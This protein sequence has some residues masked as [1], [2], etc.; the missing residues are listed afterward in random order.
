MY[1]ELDALFQARNWL[2]FFDIDYGG[3]AGGV[4]TAAC[5]PEALHSL[6]N[7]L[8][9]H[10][11]KELFANVIPTKALK[12]FDTVV[13][14]WT[15]QSKQRHMKNYAADFPRLLFPDG[16][17]SITDISAGTKIGI[18]FAIIVASLTTD[19]KHV[20]LNKADMTSEKY[21]DMVEA[22]EMLI[23]YWAWLKKDNYWDCNDMGALQH[24]KTAIK[25]QCTN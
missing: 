20:L 4:F 11:L 10:C 12:H 25:K 13:Q 17:S 22:F 14:K 7:G 1:L 21:A 23:C 19:G 15:I 2:A 8:I 5:P 24:A 18:L 9:N 16:V 3:L 6:E